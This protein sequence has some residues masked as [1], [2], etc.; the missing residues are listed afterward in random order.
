MLAPRHPPR[1]E[2]VAQ[3]LKGSGMSFAR[4]SQTGAAALDPQCE[5]LLLDS[6][7]ELLDFYAAADV[8]FVGGSLVPVGGHNLLEPAALGVPMLTGPNTFNSADIARLLI[9]RG[10]AEVVRDAAG[11]RARVSELLADPAARATHGRAR[12][13]VRGE[14]PRRAGEA[15]GADRA[16]AGGAVG[17][18]G[19][20]PAATALAAVAAAPCPGGPGSS[21]PA[22]RESPPPGTWAR[23]CS[24]RC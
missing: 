8:A 16:A 12:A 9:A 2:E 1:F 4:R 23:A 11:L 20:R 22:S 3:L 18:S 5:I 21:A 24:A 14:Q 7:G 19:A 15:P 6:L 13:R 17:P 10:A